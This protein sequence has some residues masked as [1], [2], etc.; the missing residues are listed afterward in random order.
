MRIIACHGVRVR[1]IYDHALER[2]RIEAA[3]CV[4]AH[5]RLVLA[6]G[7]IGLSLFL[8]PWGTSAHNSAIN[9]QKHRR[10]CQRKKNKEKISTHANRKTWW[11]KLFAKSEKEKEWSLRGRRLAGV[12]WGGVGW[13]R[14]PSEK[15]GRD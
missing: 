5:A 13:G 2:G 7:Y 3:F 10:L 12:G 6:A 4:R 11:C 15:E 9:G 14:R 1:K 8:L